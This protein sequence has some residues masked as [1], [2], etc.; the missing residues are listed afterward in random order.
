MFV[1]V[2]LLCNDPFLFGQSH[3]AHEV[4]DTSQVSAVKGSREKLL[5]TVESFLKQ[6]QLFLWPLGDNAGSCKHNAD[7]YSPNDC[8][9]KM[10][11]RNCEK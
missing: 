10:E 4:N 11:D 3:H 9:I 1:S 5:V 7:I 8:K 6:N 2:L